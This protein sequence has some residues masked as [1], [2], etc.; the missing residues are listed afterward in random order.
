MIDN[1]I[2]RLYTIIILFFLLYILVVNIESYL[3]Y[4][5]CTHVFLIN[6]LINFEILNIVDIIIN[7]KS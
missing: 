3:E 7:N 1:W 6:K 2:F 5:I 4:Y